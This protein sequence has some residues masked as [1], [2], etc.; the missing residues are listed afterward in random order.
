MRLVRLFLFVVT[1][2][3]ATAADIEIVCVD[4]SKLRAKLLNKNVEVKTKYG[5]LTIPAA[6]V[7]R[8]TFAMR[9]TP[10]EAKRIDDLVIGM[11]STDF[12]AREKATTEL[13]EMRE[14]AYPAL[15]KASK[16]ADAEIARRAKESVSWLEMR[17]P[18]NALQ[19]PTVDSVHVEGS[20]IRGTLSATSLRVKTT[21][22]G[23][24][25]LRLSDVRQLDAVMRPK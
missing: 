25:V 18:G 2:G 15:L 23:E 12:E 14:R 5:T 19:Q 1:P 3:P 8:I 24:Q 7:Q 13:R 21:M 17:V 4:G 16:H 10:T 20:V 6:E 22:F 9:L 11:G